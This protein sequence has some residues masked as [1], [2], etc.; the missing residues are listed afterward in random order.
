MF[1]RM[2]MPLVALCFVATSAFAGMKEENVSI[3][4]DG[5][6]VIGT[7]A[8]PDGAPAPVVVL[9]HGFTGTRN[10]LP[11]ANTQ[12]GVFSRTARMLADRGYA[13]LRIDFR[14]SGDSGSDYEN[15]TFEGQVADGIAALEFARSDQ[16]VNGGKLAIIGWSQ[17]GLV[18][19]AV[20]GRTN[21]PAATVIWNGVADPAAAFAGLLGKENLDKGL[22]LGDEAMTIKL[23]W[24]ADVKL[25]RGFFEGIAAFNPPKELA[26]Y[27]G[28]VLATQGAKDTTV[29]PDSGDRFLAAHEGEEQLWSA[30][31]D[32]VFNAFAGPETLDQ[33]IG[34]TATFLDKHLK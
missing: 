2:I 30:D 13:S 29:G 17:G 10:E 25:K 33:M 16:R 22:T 24:G 11:V 26:A 4:V 12:D 34:V 3:A 19:A 31:M 20:A 32:H 18:A 15:T 6:K 5:E 1:G 9:F 8:L 28:P 23:P 27:K 14:H 21:T 7:L